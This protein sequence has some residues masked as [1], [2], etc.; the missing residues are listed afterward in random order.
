MPIY[1]RIYNGMIDPED[2]VTHYIITVK[3]N[4]LTKE[5]VSPILL[6]KFG[7]TLSGVALTWYSLLAA[8]SIE[9]FEEMADKFVT[10]HAGPKKVET[11]VNDIFTVKQ[12]PGEGMRD[13]IAQFDKVRMTLPNIV[14]GMVVAD[15]QNRLNRKGSKA[16][17][18]LLSRLM[19]HPH[20]TWDNIHN[21]Y[22]V[23]V[24][25][26]DEDLNRPT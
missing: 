26:D 14:E 4:D 7:K 25:E 15:F 19:K 23:E 10:R 13:F 8:H 9:T 11:R 5:Q 17:R 3:G 16:T 1:P 18:K 20:P 24:K 21:A 22:C 12:S 6:K 2:H